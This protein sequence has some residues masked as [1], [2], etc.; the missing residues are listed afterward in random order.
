MY[1]TTQQ[2]L[3]KFPACE[4]VFRTKDP[5][6]RTTLLTV[7]YASLIPLI[8]VI[9]SLLIFGIFKTKQRKFT[10]SQIF[11]WHRAF[12]ITHLHFI[13]IK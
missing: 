6:A 9:N 13:E 10:P 5:D 12:T 11:I 7:I 1:S 2:F 3:Y 8:I 4:V